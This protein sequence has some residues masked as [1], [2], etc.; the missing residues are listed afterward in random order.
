MFVFSLESSVI[1]LLSTESVVITDSSPILR[2]YLPVI[3]PPTLQIYL[4][5]IIASKAINMEQSSK[6]SC[7]AD[8]QV[9]FHE[10]RCN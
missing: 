4:G 6:S 9:L 5:E 1:R 8:T 10:K 7:K 2:P 3:S